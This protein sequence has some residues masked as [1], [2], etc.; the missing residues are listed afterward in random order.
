MDTIVAPIT[1]LIV[2]S[3]IVIRISGPNALKALNFIKGEK[4]LLPKRIYYGT[5]N[6]VNQKLHDSVLYY[7]FKA[8]NSYTGE[9]VLEI[10][11]HGNPVIVQEAILSLLKL[12]FRIA[13]PGEFTKRAFLNGKIDLTQAE[14]V[15]D[16]INSKNDFA[17]NTAFNQLKGNIKLKISEI[18][19]MFID[20]LSDIE[21]LIDYT[22]EEDVIDNTD[23]IMI[24]IYD[25]KNI[26]CHYL[27][28]YKKY[29]ELLKKNIN[30]LI[31]GK[32]NVGKSSLFNALVGTDRSIISEFPGTTRDYVEKNIFMGNVSINLIDTA[33]IRENAEYI[34]KSGIEKTLKLIN[35]AQLILFVLD[36]SNEINNSD[37]MIL[38][39]IEGKNRI[40]I[41]NKM[42]LPD[43]FEHNVDIKISIKNNINI[44]KLSELIVK[45]LFNSDYSKDEFQLVLQ[46][47]HVFLLEK[48]YEILD[49]LESLNIDEY[50]DIYASELQ[51][52]I[53]YISEITG[54]IYTEDILNN[55]FSKFCVG[56]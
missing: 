53:K 56:K 11:F 35:E 3:I 31:V 5:F 42:D 40:V 22:E 54:E 10:S 13:E 45:K 39:L 9:D 48:V 2:S 33:G 6:D 44:D 1:P 49:S 16:I 46:E 41:G 43:L 25:V 51:R 28:N 38:K 21:A 7:Y 14:A 36:L 55:I 27:N 19:D 37:R 24:K 8:P 52:G 17:I 32:T 29:Y 4:K 23:K 47:R 18:K 26:I 12:G 20:I 30:V 34:E 50:I 15:M